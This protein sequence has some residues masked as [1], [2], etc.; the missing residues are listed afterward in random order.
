VLEF[1]TYYAAPF[2]T[3][4]LADLGARVIKVEQL[5]GDPIRNMFPF[6]ELAGIKVLQGKESAAID[7]TSEDGRAL[8]LELVRRAD[9]VLQSFRAGVAERLGY[10]AKDLLAVNPRL[11]YLNAPGYGNDGPMGHRPAFAPTIGAAS[12]LGFRN[13]GGSQ[14]VPQDPDMSVEDVKRYT[15]RMSSST[16]VLGQADGF[17]ALGVA[18]ALL[19]GV[20]TQKRDGEGQ[21]MS[22][23]MLST[24]AHT[25]SEDMVEYADRPK[26]AAPDQDLYG[27]APLYRL[28]A[29]ADDTWLFLAAPADDDWA[30]VSSALDLPADLR[31]HDDKLAVVLAERFAQR[32]AA[33][34]EAELGALDVACVEVARQPVEDVVWL[35]G[36]I[37]EAMDIV[38]PAV[39]PVVGDYLRLKP[40]VRFSRSGGVA[41]PAPLVGEH[42]DKILAELGHDADSIAAL[43]KKGVL[44]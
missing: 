29:A 12:G 20:F 42:T 4:V 44:G 41:G 22:S 16:T 8:V 3:S 14:N 40:M 27:L 5:D 25:L 24:M 30:A 35:E 38:T 10:T 6:P 9:V 19:L 37:G 18:T 11:V 33:D 43:R 13:L 39:H 34:W 17:S 26:L 1:G 21:E 23:S 36:G 2:G 28:Y 15:M 32:P 7:I 31:D